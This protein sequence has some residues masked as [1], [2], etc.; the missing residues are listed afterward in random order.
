MKRIRFPTKS[1]NGLTVG[2]LLLER[3][4]LLSIAALIFNLAGCNSE[5]TAPE[6]A[7]KTETKSPT[8]SGAA[9]DQGANIDSTKQTIKT[10]QNA[11]QMFAVEHDAEWPKSLDD[12][13]KPEMIGGELK[14][15]Y[16]DQ[17]PTDAWGTPIQYKYTGGEE[18]PVITSFGPDK[19]EGGGDDITNRDDEVQTEPIERKK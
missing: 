3:I 12:L 9:A 16:L 4:I 14:R 17:P 5:K 13:T 18:E 8:P 19:K 15:P 10:L 6:P 2:G 1:R 11:A 7:N